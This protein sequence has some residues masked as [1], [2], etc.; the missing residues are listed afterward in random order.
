MYLASL[1]VDGQYVLH[2]LYKTYEEAVRARR[3]AELQYIASQRIEKAY[4][5]YENQFPEVRE[6]IERPEGEGRNTNRPEGEGRNT[7]TKE[8][9]MED[10]QL[11]TE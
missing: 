1:M 2:R 8:L 3:N 5:E 10:K 11:W 4:A 6:M 9:L 7:E